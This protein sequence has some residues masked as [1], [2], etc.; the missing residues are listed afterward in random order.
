M[1][2]AIAAAAVRH[3]P[4]AAGAAV[5]LPLVSRTGPTEV[6]V[7]GAHHPVRE[8]LTTASPVEEARVGDAPVPGPPPSRIPVAAPNGRDPQARRRAAV[9]VPADRRSGADEGR[10]PALVGVAAAD[11]PPS[12]TARVGVPPKKVPTTPTPAPP[13]IRRGAGAQAGRV[14]HAPGPVAPVRARLAGPPHRLGR[15]TTG[16]GHPRRPAPDR[17]A[18][19]A[20]PVER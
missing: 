16:S 20:G 8:H 5:P 17:V 10:G 18:A 4:G 11:P 15:A 6:V 3:P 9:L 13:P 14:V 1:A 19:L 12:T 2:E 7:V